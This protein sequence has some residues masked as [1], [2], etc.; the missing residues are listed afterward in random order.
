MND[1]ATIVV[2]HISRQRNQSLLNISQ[3]LGLEAGTDFLQREM[4]RVISSDAIRHSRQ[5][6]KPRHLPP[7]PGKRVQRHLI[8][9]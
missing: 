2:V 7:H 5:A 8:A 6:D 3:D 4:N 1:V 9:G